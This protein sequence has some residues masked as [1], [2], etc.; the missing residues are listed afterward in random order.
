MKNPKAW[1]QSSNGWERV[2]V[3]LTIFGLLYALYLSVYQTNQSQIGLYDYKTSIHEEYQLPQC[4]P[5]INEPI[6]KLKE[7]EDFQEDCWYIYTHRKYLTKDVYPYTEEM[8]DKKINLNYWGGLGL[9]FTVNSLIAI[10]LSVILYF[11]GMILNWI[12]KG[13]KGKVK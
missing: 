2:W 6:S 11:S 4:K 8:Y 13:F 10:I 1:L 5:Y 9:L 12:L 3:V 7:P